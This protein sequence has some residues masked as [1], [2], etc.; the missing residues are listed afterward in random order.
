[1]KFFQASFY[2]YIL[3]FLSCKSGCVFFALGWFDEIGLSEEWEPIECFYPFESCLNVV[4]IQ[5][6]DLLEELK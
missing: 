3:L 5:K 1:M 2:V 4:E 6:L